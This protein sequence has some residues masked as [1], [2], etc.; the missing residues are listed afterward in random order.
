MMKLQPD[1][2]PPATFSFKYYFEPKAI[3]EL[4][5]RCTGNDALCSSIQLNFTTSSIKWKSESCIGL[6]KTLVRCNGI[7]EAIKHN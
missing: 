5:I 6:F 7:E 1:K 3:D 4:L 2:L